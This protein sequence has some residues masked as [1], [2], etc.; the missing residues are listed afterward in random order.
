MQKTSFLKYA[1]IACCIA[2]SGS[3]MSAA[4]SD[5]ELQSIKQYCDETNSFGSFASE[6]ERMQA[7]SSCITEEVSRA[8]EYGNP[9]AMPY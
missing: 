8:S 3:A 1:F 9:V 5:D 7:V 2:A 6:E 4:V